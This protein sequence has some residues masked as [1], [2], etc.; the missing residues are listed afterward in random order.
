[1]TVFQ[2][3][4]KE[5]N[6][7]ATTQ[8][9]TANSYEAK[10]VELEAAYS[11]GDFRI[12]GGV[13]FTDAEITGTAAADVAL[14]GN[15]PRRQARVVYQLAPTYEWGPATFGASLVGT[16]KSWGDDAHTITLPAY[17]VLNAFVNYQLTP[18]MQVA[19]TANNLLNKIGYTEVEGDGHAARS[20][21]G[22]AVKVSLKYAF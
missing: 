3:K 12:N 2:A 20:I 15:T 18:Q 9:R 5:S 14:I 7:E 19:L 4:T 22:R 10:G 8:L 16:G 13:T 11:N 17:Q 6:Y 21:T 1:M